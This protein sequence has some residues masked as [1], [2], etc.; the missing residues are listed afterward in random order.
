MTNPEPTDAF[1]FQA[2][3]KQLLDILV[4][5]L[6]QEREI[7]L[8][9]LISNA[10]DA[11]TQIHFL[12]LT[13]N[14]VLDADAELAIYLSVEE[15]DGEK[16]LIVRDTGIGMT[17]EELIQNLGTI[18]QSGARAFLQRLQE[19]QADAADIIGQFGVGFYSVFM[20]A[21]VVRVVSHSYQPDAEAAAWISQ[22]EETFRVETAQ[23]DDRGTEIQIR[24]KNDAEE[25]ASAWKLKEIVKR[26]SDFVGRPIYLEGEQINQQQPLWRRSPSDVSDEEYDNFYQQMTMDF[27]EPLAHIHLHS[28]APVHVRA[29][30]FVPAT[31]DRGVLAKRNQPGIQLYSRNVLIQEYNTDLLPKWLSFIDGVVDSEDLPLNVSRETVQSNRL[32]RQLGVTLRRRATRTLLDLAA[33]DADAFARFWREHSRALKEGLVTD[34]VAV[35]DVVPL[36]RFYSTADEDALTSLKEYVQRMPAEQEAIYYVL[37]DSRQAVRHSPHL[38]PFRTRNIEVLFWVDPLDPFLVPLLNEYEDKPLKNVDDAGLELPGEETDE[39]IAPAVDEPA[40]NRLIGRCVTTLGDRVTEVRASRVLRNS[41]VRL[42]TP[43][44]APNREMQ[45]LYRY[46]NEEYEIP[47]RILEINPRHPL[48]S[49]LAQLVT[50]EP[51]NPLINLSIEQLFASAL[52]QEGL[53]PNPAEMLPRIQELIEI[54]VGEATRERGGE[55]VEDGEP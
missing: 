29:L 44:E 23:K 42:V 49:N 37:G 43:E 33:E 25:F 14:D 40:L 38:D 6:Y 11:L 21:D 2:E 27:N 39:E 10:A 24:L 53:H 48:V 18:A 55:A 50:D 5:S 30:L 7:F 9:E 19:Q 15:K 46:L 17:R 4:H 3:I 22:G 16:W 20:V 31:R 41:P 35:K 51:D 32:L 54:A 1:R 8:R 45:R 47:R 52:I 12:M 36:L 26:H 13:E 28:D 34:P